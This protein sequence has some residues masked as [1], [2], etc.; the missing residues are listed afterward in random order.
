MPPTETQTTPQNQSPDATTNNNPQPTTTTRTPSDGSTRSAKRP[1]KAVPEKKEK[2]KRYFITKILDKRVQNGQIEYLVRWKPSNLESDTVPFVPEIV[3]EFERSEQKPTLS[4]SPSPSFT[5]TGKRTRAVSTTFQPPEPKSAPEPA[6][7]SSKR[8]ASTTAVVTSKSSDPSVRNPKRRTLSSEPASLL[9]SESSTRNQKQSK[10]SSSPVLPPATTTPTK[11]RLRKNPPARLTPDLTFRASSSRG[12]PAPS[13]DTE[14]E[15]ALDRETVEDAPVLPPPAAN[16]SKR[17]PTLRVESSQIEESLLD[18][19]EKEEEIVQIKQEPQEPSMPPHNGKIGGPRL[20]EPP[21]ILLISDDEDEGSPPPPPRRPS[22]K[23]SQRVRKAPP[24]VDLLGSSGSDE[25]REKREK[26]MG[27]EEGDEGT[28]V[29]G[30]GSGRGTEAM[31]L[32]DEGNGGGNVRGRDNDGGK[33]NDASEMNA[34]IVAQGEEHLKEEEREPQTVPQMELQME[35]EQVPVVDTEMYGVEGEKQKIQVPQ[36]FQTN[37]G[38]KNSSK[39]PVMN[40]SETLQN[41]SLANKDIAVVHINEYVVPAAPF[42]PPSHTRPQPQIDDMDTESLYS[43]NSE[44]ET[45]SATD[46]EPLALRAARRNKGKGKLV[47]SPLTIE[48]TAPS[49][50]D[51]HDMWIPVRLTAVQQ[52]LYNGIREDY[53]DPKKPAGRSLFRKTLSKLLQCCNHPALEGMSGGMG[54]EG[55]GLSTWVDAGKLSLLNGVFEQL[56][57]IGQQTI[58]ILCDDMELESQLLQFCERI[59]HFP[60]FRLSAVL[61]FTPAH[62]GVVVITSAMV[63]KNLRIPPN[64]QVDL[65]IA[66]DVHIGGSDSILQNF[67]P[68]EHQKQIPMVWFITPGTAEEAFMYVVHDFRTGTTRND[69]DLQ[70]P[71]LVSIIMAHGNAEKPIRSVDWRNDDVEYKTERKVVMRMVE[72][73]KNKC[74]GKF[75]LWYDW[76]MK[77]PVRDEMPSGT[78]VDDD[79]R[80]ANEKRQR[81]EDSA[82]KE[83]TP[84]KTARLDLVQAASSPRS[85]APHHPPT[86]L[87]I[88]TSSPI[89][90]SSRR[91]PHAIWN[92]PMNSLPTAQ[93]PKSTLPT[94]QPP[95]PISLEKSLFP[96]RSPSNVSNGSNVVII[97]DDPSALLDSVPNSANASGSAASSTVSTQKDIGVIP[98]QFGGNKKELCEH[99]LANPQYLLPDA[100][101][102]ELYRYACQPNDPVFHDPNSLTTFGNTPTMVYELKYLEDGFPGKNTGPGSVCLVVDRNSAKM[103]TLFIVQRL[104]AELRSHNHMYPPIPLPKNTTPGGIHGDQTMQSDDVLDSVLKSTKASST[105]RTSAPPNPP[106]APRSIAV[107]GDVPHLSISHVYDSTIAC[108]W[109]RCSFKALNNADFLKHVEMAHLV[110]QLTSSQ[111]SPATSSSHSSSPNT[112][113]RIVGPVAMPNFSKFFNINTWV[114]FLAMMAKEIE[115]GSAAGPLEY[116]EFL[117]TVRTQCVSFSRLQNHHHDLAVQQSNSLLIK[118][119]TLTT[120]LNKVGSELQQLQSDHAAM[121]A[122]LKQCQEENMQL[123]QQAGQLPPSNNAIVVELTEKCARLENTL[124]RAYQGRASIET[125][126]GVLQTQ[127]QQE[128]VRMTHIQQEHAKMIQLTGQQQTQLSQMAKKMEVEAEARRQYETNRAQLQGQLE[129]LREQN[130]RMGEELRARKVITGEQARVAGE[131]VQTL[132]KQIGP[133]GMQTGGVG[134]IQGQLEEGS[135][136][137]ASVKVLETAIV[138]L[139]DQIPGVNSSSSGRT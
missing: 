125:R 105:P 111:T 1:R 133:A 52:A 35:P 90:T 3:E 26:V 84:T 88:A 45:D 22:P 51:L 73:L 7:H 74:V 34:E 122:R 100:V 132:R 89:A 21:K 75:G 77:R 11:P 82:S 53:N 87:S 79:Q 62:N 126:M 36:F 99:M 48:A 37:E 112:L 60:T 38:E 91:T 109:N 129:L 2:E 55:G 131:Q 127:L 24:K 92:D 57:E 136:E 59:H 102:Q 58:A 72:F 96:L 65:V 101:K 116:I 94:P 78:G 20:R 108:G 49:M 86:P 107:N 42:L 130:K 17:P 39:G 128:N 19:S 115:A 44:T 23:V 56:E 123:R 71:E 12:S 124:Q 46:I 63:G 121:R 40:Y 114:D 27:A 68:R 69:S 25:E 6:V 106:L 16:K 134:L 30:Q 95:R 15:T 138:T 43:S 47:T 50:P 13:L 31:A 10:S 41:G 14:S 113:R 67:K 97:D 137:V 76:R 120:Q 104:V 66:Y 18:L 70:T 83:H 33:T 135:G 5:K 93:T 61:D 118:N 9:A 81:D 8:R 80:S 85:P 139:K 29:N 54:E 28:S 119:N 103:T 64:P 110:K 32:D 117:R 98:V 4:P